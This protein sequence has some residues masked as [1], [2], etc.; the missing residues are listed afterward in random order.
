MMMMNGGGWWS[1][2]R[3][4][5]GKD[6]PTISRAVLRR[7]AGYARP[8][9]GRIALML[10]TILVITVLPLLPP[11]LMRELIDVALPSRDLGLLNVLAIGMVAVPLING[12]IGV[13][14]RYLGSQIGEGIIADLRSALFNHLQRQSL[15]FFTNSKT[16]ELMARVNNDVV[17]AQRAINGTVVEVVSNSIALVATLSIMIALEWRLTLAGILILPLFIIPARRV[18]NVLRRVTRDQ[19]TLN[20]KMNGMMSETLNVSGALLVKLFGREQDESGRFAERAVA[21]RDAGIRAALIGRWFFLMLGLVSAVGTATVFWAGGYLVL[22]EGLTIGTVVAF[23]AYLGQL[24]GPLSALTNARVELATSLVSFERVFEILDLPIEIQEPELSVRL[25]RARGELTFQNVSFSYGTTPEGTA[26]AQIE[27]VERFSWG[28]GGT[29]IEGFKP[30]GGAD[31][32]TRWALRNID[33]TVAPGQLVAL[34]G[35]SGAGKTTI[36]YL[37]PR[38]YD[39]SEGRVLLDGH[40]LRTLSLRS[41]ADQIGMVTQETHLF[42]DTIRAN[43]LY[44]RPDATQAEIETACRAANIHDVIAR[45]PDGYETVVGERGYRLSGGEKQ[46]LA[47]ARVLLKDPCILVLDEATAHL[48]SESEAL[49]QHALEQAMRHRTSLVI[50][51]RLST[52]LA[53]DKILV[54][55]DGMLVEQGTHAELLA[56][57][58]LYARLYETQFRG[59]AAGVGA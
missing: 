16:G 4:D 56:R 35:P 25:D 29:L 37:I 44:A 38:L 11:L 18:G 41:L 42:H 7:V 15:R 43:L 52:I 59:V 31:Q 30:R 6:R 22:T 48:D 39:P 1:F 14:Q 2:L 53:A 20:A 46:R 8:Y 28:G 23:A 9:L 54:L 19:M 3:H 32:G 47:I 10:L 17:G 36:T 57:G 33:F 49:I 21:V 12:L 24:Y 27:E 34:V 58:G 13:G 45:L 55:D 51:H 40:D 50:A 26:P 5:D